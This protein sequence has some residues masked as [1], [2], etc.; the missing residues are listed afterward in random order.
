MSEKFEST[1][2]SYEKLILDQSYELCSDC[3]Q[4]KTYCDWCQ[5]CSSKR[6]KQ[7]FSKWTSG[8]QHID[9]FIQDAQLKARNTKEV[10]EWTP[11]DHTVPC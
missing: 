6:F 9:R 2:S 5:N 4:P 8:N 3:N 7:E 11:Y 1:L 10:I